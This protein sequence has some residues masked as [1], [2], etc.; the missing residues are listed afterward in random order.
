LRK[1]SSLKKANRIKLES[2]AKLGTKKKETADKVSYAN[3]KVYDYDVLKY[4]SAFINV[5]NVYLNVVVMCST[6]AN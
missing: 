3:F 5:H 1:T 2:P 6:V 4:L